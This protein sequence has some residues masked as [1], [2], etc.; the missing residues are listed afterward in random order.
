MNNTETH[1]FTE[2]SPPTVTIKIHYPVAG[3]AAGL[4]YLSGLAMWD[5]E[6][7]ELLG[8]D[9]RGTTLTTDEDVI[10]RMEAVFVRHVLNVAAPHGTGG[11]VVEFVFT[12][13]SSLPPQIEVWVDDDELDYDEARWR[14][15]IELE[16]YDLIASD[17]YKWHEISSALREALAQELRGGASDLKRLPEL[18]R[19]NASGI[20]KLTGLKL[21]S[22]SADQLQELPQTWRDLIADS[23]SANEPLV[24]RQMRALC[25]FP[26]S[27]R[28]KIASA[29]QVAWL[30]AGEARDWILETKQH[31]DSRDVHEWG[32]ASTRVNLDGAVAV[33]RSELGLTDSDEDAGGREHF[34]DL[35]VSRSP[36]DFDEDDTLEVP[37]HI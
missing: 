7:V 20:I 12:D 1:P 36:G 15:C 23:R 17:D 32:D 24:I 29:G 19:L 9:H 28:I 21:D 34:N 25:R 2:A 4:A 6:A 18:T 13:D 37:I 31:L 35:E 11:Q 27:K 33:Y 10:D 3:R 22:F 5:E 30:G 16:M 14:H 8:G 26:T